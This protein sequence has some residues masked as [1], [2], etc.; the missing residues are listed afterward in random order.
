MK[1]SQMLMKHTNYLRNQEPK[2]GF[3]IIVKRKD[4]FDR[5]REKGK[6]G[7]KTNHEK[8]VDQIS[9]KG[10]LFFT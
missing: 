5:K 7:E 1:F 3:K 9:N 8:I 6:K 10:T 4:S 2:K